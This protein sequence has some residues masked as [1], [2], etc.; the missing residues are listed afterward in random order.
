MDTIKIKHKHTKMIAHRG[1]SGIERENTACAFIAA[2]NRTYY[3]CECDVRLSKDNVLVIAHDDN[4]RRNAGLDVLIKDCTYEELDNVR[5]YDVVN[6]EPSDY[7]SVLTFE[8]YIKICKR[9]DKNCIIEYKQDY[10]K[11]EIERFIDIINKNEYMNKCVF[12]SFYKNPLVITRELLNNIE[13]QF[14]NDKVDE[15]T[16]EFC[17]KYN[18]GLDVHHK[19]INKE[20]VK[21]FHK[22]NLKV[23]VWT[24]DD[25]EL[26]KKYIK[27]GVDYITTNILE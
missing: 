13:I 18:F 8:D 4:L 20:V 24:V 1:L 21:R 14:L 7:Y 2:G 9:Y 25:K 17:K 27:M 12:I 15:E 5:M 23:N 11:E 26:A 6:K 3:G 10:N 22:E 16:F 19:A